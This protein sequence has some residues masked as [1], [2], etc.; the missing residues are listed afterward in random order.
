MGRATPC[1]TPPAGSSALA[2]SSRPVA[3]RGPHRQGDR[4]GAEAEAPS[5]RKSSASIWTT[6]AWPPCGAS[7]SR[8]PCS[9]SMTAWRSGSGTRPATSSPLAGTSRAGTPGAGARARRK[10]AA[11]AR[12]ARAGRAQPAPRTSGWSSTRRPS[13]RW[14]QCRWERPTTCWTMCTPGVL[15]RV[16]SATRTTTSSPRAPRLAV[17]RQRGSSR[18]R[19]RGPAAPSARRRRGW[20]CL[21]RTAWPR[22]GTRAPT[23]PRST[24]SSS[25][26]RPRRRWAASRC[27]T[28][29]TSSTRWPSRA[30]R[31]EISRRTSCPR[32]PKWARAARASREERP[33]LSLT[34]RAARGPR[35]A[36]PKAARAARAAARAAALPPGSKRAFSS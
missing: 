14:P 6:S 22:R 17:F 20:P 10:A 30:A 11:R 19:S 18:G 34:R 7:R 32:S 13:T 33:L 23:V 3:A 27:G 21:P 15:G 9:C 1:A 12:A 31:S 36:R 2:A 4:A 24:V 25:P 26:R 16:A 8:K 5:V 28:R 29:W 35:A